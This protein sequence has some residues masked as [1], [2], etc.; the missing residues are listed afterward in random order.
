MFRDCFG[1]NQSFREGAFIVWDDSEGDPD[2]EALEKMGD[3]K[4]YVT[5]KGPHREHWEMTKRGYDAGK[6]YLS[7]M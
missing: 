2:F 4:K 6:E 1:I 3:I 7:T 5:E